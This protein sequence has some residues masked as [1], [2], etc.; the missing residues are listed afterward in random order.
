[1]RS[2][3]LKYQVWITPIPRGQAVF[4]KDGR[5]IKKRVKRKSV[6]KGN[7]IIIYIYILYIFST[8]NHGLSYASRLVKLA[9]VHNYLIYI[10]LFNTNI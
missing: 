4:N 8:H 6:E 2:E 3:R 5:K 1:M 9:N 7:T 10:Q